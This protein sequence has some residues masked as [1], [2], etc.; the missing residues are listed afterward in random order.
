MGLHDP[1]HHGQTK[2]SAP[3]VGSRRKEWIEGA[4]Q[5]AFIHT[6]ARYSSRFALR[7]HNGN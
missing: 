6:E 2:P 7:A 5:R 4:S 1:M 3:L